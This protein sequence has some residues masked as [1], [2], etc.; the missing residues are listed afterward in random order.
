MFHTSLSGKRPYDSPRR[1]KNLRCLDAVRAAMPKTEEVDLYKRLGVAKDASDADIKKAYRKLALTHHP[2]KGGD[3]ETF[4]GLAEAYAVLSDAEKRRVYDATGTLE[5][6]DVDIEE[7]MSSGVI[8]EFFQEMMLESGMMDEMAEMY[9]DDVSMGELQKSFESFFKASMGFGTGPVLMPDGSYI[10]A[11][12]VPK[13]SQMDLLDDFGEE[14]DLDEEELMAMMAMMGGKG[15]LPKGLLGMP[16]GMKMPGGM[17]GGGGRRRGAGRGASAARR[18]PKMGGG[19][20]G[21]RPTLDDLDDDDDEAELEAMLAA[22]MARKHGGGGRAG[23]RGGGR[24]GGGMGGM[25]GGMPPELMAMMIGG[26]GGKG[27]PDEG[28]L[29]AMMAMMG[30]M[31]LGGGM[32]GGG[33]GGSGGSGKKKKKKKKMGEGGSSTKGS[34]SRSATPS[35]PRTAAKPRSSGGSS[36][37]GGGGGG[38]GAG[39]S[40]AIDTSKSV[41]EQWQQAAKIGALAHMQ[42][43]HAED[44][45]LLQK[46]AR[47][48]GHTALHWSAAN[49][50]LSVVSWLLDAGLSPN[51]RNNGDSTPLHSAAGAGHVDVVQL[52]L[53]RGADKAL[54]DSGGEKAADLAAARGHTAVVAAL[55]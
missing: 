8:E 5:M 15:G 46:K 13:M 52:L 14:E 10:D 36:S 51:V 55:A 41:D 6:T 22:A 53:N 34:G 17:G 47:G 3:P 33:G 28:E 43:L 50:Q 26:K 29:M 37:S 30:G 12:D 18:K 35:P 48:I 4:K 24:G 2:D 32:G 40:A 1:E 31:G 16:P 54:G 42:K 44:S 23:S 45:S 7:F 38:A 21:G 9:G 11:A 39:S 27:M 49:G 19:T 20:G 25:M